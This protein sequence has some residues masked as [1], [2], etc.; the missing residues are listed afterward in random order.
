MIYNCASDV[1]GELKNRIL[2]SLRENLSRVSLCLCYV[3]FR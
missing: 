1:Q 2:E 3:L